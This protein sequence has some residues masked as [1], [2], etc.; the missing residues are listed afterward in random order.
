MKPDAA[1]LPALLDRL[2]ALYGAPPRPLP[3]RA[4]DWVLWENAAYLVSDEKRAAAFRALKQATGLRAAGLL[5]LPRAELLAIARLGGMLP[6]RRVEKLLAIAETVEEDFDGDLESAL[7][8][9][10]AQARRALKKFPGIGDPGAD[11]ILLVT[12]T[13]PLPSVESNGL[14]TLIRLGLVREAKNYGTTYRAAVTVLAPFAERGCG[15]LTR[16]FELLRK[17]GQTLCKTNDP[18]CDECPLAADC[19]SA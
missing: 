3:R 19:P 4:L 5:A 13:H 8:L 18:L 9:P 12:G 14:R 11:K 7:R 1:Q 10:L 6:D 2:E 15:W 17:H 16:A